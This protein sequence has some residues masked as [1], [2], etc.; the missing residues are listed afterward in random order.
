MP[1]PKDIIQPLVDKRSEILHSIR[2]IFLSNEDAISLA[3]EVRRNLC[4]GMNLAKN[5]WSR[6]LADRIR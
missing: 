6:S 3:K 1:F 2:Q 4:E 5:R